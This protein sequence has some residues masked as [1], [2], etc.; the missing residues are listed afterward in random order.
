MP[1]DCATL[2][3]GV[4]SIAAMRDETTDTEN[5]QRA[6]DE[7][8]TDQAVPI[9]R[10][11]ENQHAEQELHGWCDELQE[12]HQRQRNIRRGRREQ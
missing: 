3:S 5:N 6:P 4:L 1:L 7:C 8:K 9:E 12:T 11:M 10:F 2:C